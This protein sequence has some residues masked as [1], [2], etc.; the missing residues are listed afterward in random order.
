M[1]YLQ[2]IL[3]CLCFSIEV[4]AQTS[5]IQDDFEG[6][7]T[8]STWYGDDCNIN[9]TL[10]NPFQLGINTSATVLEYN[11]SGGQYANVRFDLSTNF[12]LS[13]HHT[14]SLKIYVPSIGLTGSQTNQV[15]LKLQ[16]G[17][18]GAPWSTQSEII[19]QI[20][21]DQWQ[22]ITFDFENDTYINLDPGSVPPIQRNDFNRVVIQVNGEN[23]FDHVLAYLD[24]VN[25]DGTMPGGSV[26]DNLVWSDEFDEDGAINNT[27]WFHQKQLPAGGSW[28]NGEVQHYTDRVDNSFVEDGV[29]KI[30]AKKETFTDQGYTKE[31]TSARLNSKFSFK[32]GRVEVRAKLPSGIGTWP[33]IWML[34]KNIDEDGAYWDNLGYGTTSW[35]EC[36][37]VDIMEHWGSNQ[38]YVQSATHTPSSYGGTV[39]LGGRTVENVSGE[40]HVYT[41]EWT[42]E[43]LVFSV[44]NIVHYTYNPS[45]KDAGTWPFDLEQYLIFNVAVLPNIEVSFTNSAM[46]IDYVRVYQES[47]ISNINI[48]KD[49]NLKVF[50]NP[51]SNELNIH[52]EQAVEQNVAVSI[53]SIDGRLINKNYASVN[54]NKLTINGMG[55]LTKGIYI[56]A[57]NLGN[58]HHRVKVIKK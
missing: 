28:F 24:N 45:P 46:E 19:K 54:N 34:G 51:F 39:N 20:S 35:P 52:F 53:Y 32:Y 22:I 48:Q 47:T 1:R 21:L 13:T 12:E 5:T 42:A 14:F 50:P 40:F 30:V 57:F 15:S 27:K 16:D 7:G 37:E 41:V 56:M 8:I 49:Q 58:E 4:L 6:N 29:L 44:D 38:N 10:I 11:D 43:K 31:Y 3:L 9:T 36:G 55:S 25:Y 2:F 23:N 18:I 33:A 17:T 26:F